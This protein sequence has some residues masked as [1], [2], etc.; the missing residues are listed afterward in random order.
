MARWPAR[1][2]GLGKV[3]PSRVMSRANDSSRARQCGDASPSLSAATT[4]FIS[5]FRPEAQ[6]RLH[7]LRSSG[8]EGGYCESFRSNYT[9]LLSCFFNRRIQQGH[10]GSMLYFVCVDVVTHAANDR[11][12]IQT[13]PLQLKHSRLETSWM[14]GPQR[15]ILI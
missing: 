11:W 12:C 4:V 1:G 15:T 7:I 10:H 5:Y 8:F 13:V 9:I 14:C 6:I 3:L 2:E